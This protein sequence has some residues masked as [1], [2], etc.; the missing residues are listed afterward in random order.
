MLGGTGAVDVE[1]V[2]KILFVSV[3]FDAEPYLLQVFCP[4]TYDLKVTSFTTF[5]ANS[6]ACTWKFTA[7][8]PAENIASN[9]PVGDQV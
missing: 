9:D 2:E 5:V 6:T 1:G 8:M 4:S 7:A 3:Q